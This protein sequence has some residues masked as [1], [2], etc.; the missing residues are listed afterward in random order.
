VP[1]QSF[2]TKVLPYNNI[3]VVRLINRNL[4]D[5]FIV[6]LGDNTLRAASHPLRSVPVRAQRAVPRGERSRGVHVPGGLR[7]RPAQLSARVRAERGVSQQQGV[8]SAAL[9]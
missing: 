4:V 6:A 3:I 2:Q 7:G 5:D 1:T 8:Y 9:W